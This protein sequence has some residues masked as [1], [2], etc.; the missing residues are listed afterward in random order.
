MILFL[1][2]QRFVLRASIH[3]ALYSTTLIHFAPSLP[4]LSSLVTTGPTNPDTVGSYRISLLYFSLGR[5]DD[6]HNVRGDNNN[7]NNN[8]NN[9]DNNEYLHGASSLIS[10]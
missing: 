6:T 8:N 3:C 1:G 5:L 10:S 4:V 9:N 2:N 7:N